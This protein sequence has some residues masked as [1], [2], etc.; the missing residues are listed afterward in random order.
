MIQIVLESTGKK[1]KLTDQEWHELRTL[2]GARDLPQP[3]VPSLRPQG[4]DLTKV[5]NG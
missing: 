1:L 4:P 5:R 3:V 2:T